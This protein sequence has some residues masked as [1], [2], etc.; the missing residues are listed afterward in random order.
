MWVLG[1]I[2]LRLRD[3]RPRRRGEFVPTLTITTAGHLSTA[4]PEAAPTRHRRPRIAAPGNSGCGF[5]Q[6]SCP[7]PQGS[8][9][10]G[11]LG[12][13]VGAASAPRWGVAHRGKGSRSGPAETFPSPPEVAPTRHRRPRIADSL[14]RS[15]H[16]VLL[17]SLS[18][19]SWHSGT[20]LTRQRQ[21]QYKIEGETR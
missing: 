19:Q 5:G 3:L 1:G 16:S 12:S 2:R 17:P 4:P 8:A 6:S 14:T 15:R 13:R 7:Q 11:R 10:D 20:K 9:C 18:P 21:K